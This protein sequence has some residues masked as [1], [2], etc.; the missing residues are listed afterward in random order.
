[1]VL[2]QIPAYA[3]SMQ[4]ACQRRNEAA[5]MYNSHH[6]KNKSNNKPNKTIIKKS[7]QIY[8]KDSTQDIQK[9]TTHAKVDTKVDIEKWILQA[10]LYIEPLEE[11]KRK[12]MLMMLVDELHRE[13]LESHSLFDRAIH[14]DEHLEHMFN[15]IRTMY[16]RKEGSPIEIKNKFLKRT[17]RYDEPITDFAMEMRETLYQAWPGLPRDQLEHLLIEYFI[18]GLYNQETGNK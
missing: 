1:M 11:Y 14:T 18:N 2:L 17:Q 15:V 8:Q 6:N 7:F 16:K 13:R 12:D 5:S 10:K 9:E 4:I 3:E